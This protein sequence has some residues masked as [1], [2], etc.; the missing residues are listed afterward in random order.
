MKPILKP[1]RELRAGDVLWP[2]HRIAGIALADGLIGS[3]AFKT[4][5]ALRV[6]LADGSTHLLHPTQPMR[7][8]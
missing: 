4:G 7:I 8:E 5:A 6:T 1:A 3:R 2:G